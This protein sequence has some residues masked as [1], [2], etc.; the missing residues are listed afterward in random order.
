MLD[1][2]DT[3]NYVQDNPV[4]E[5]KDLGVTFEPNLKF[6]KHIA[7]CVNKTQRV[8]AVIRRSLI[9][10]GEGNVSNIVCKSIVQPLFEYST[11]VWSPY[12][13]KDKR[14]LDKCS[15]TC[16]KTCSLFQKC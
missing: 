13:K 12:L 10:F 16:Y 7:N 1:N 15:A 8:L 9:L 14:K 6:D 4:N 5:E 2:E 3:C 11:T